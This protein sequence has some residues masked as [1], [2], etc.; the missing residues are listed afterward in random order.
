MFVA[1][2]GGH[3]DAQRHDKR[4]GHRTGGHAA[5]VKRDGDEILR[6][7]RSQHEHDAVAHDQQPVL[8]NAQQHTEHRDAQKQPDADRDGRNQHGVRH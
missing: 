8:R 6:D 2:D 1:S 7:Q 3:T 5:G 4:N